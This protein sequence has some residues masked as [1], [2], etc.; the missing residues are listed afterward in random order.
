MTN[1]I[2][3]LDG[4][5]NHDAQSDF[6]QA[7]P[8][9][10]TKICRALDSRDANGV[11]QR[12]YYSSGVGAGARPVSKILG[13]AFGLGIT[14]SILSAYRWL[15]GN[16]NEDSDRLFLFGFSRGAYAVRS[17]VGM[18]QV[19][20]LA[21]PDA[22]A[23][24]EAYLLY[25]LQTTGERKLR[26]AAETFKSQQ[27]QISVHFIGVWDTVGSVGLPAITRYRLL[28]AFWNQITSGTTLKRNIHDN[29]LPSIVSHAY[30]AL[31]M[32]E[33]RFQFVPSVWTDPDGRN[34]QNV[35]QVWFRGSHSNIGGGYV[36]SGLSDYALM[37]MVEKAIKAGLKFNLD[38][39][40]LRAD[41]NFLGALR[42]SFRGVS[43]L[44]PP[45]YREIGREHGI[46]ESVHYSVME[47]AMSTGDEPPYCKGVEWNQMLST[48]DGAR[49]IRLLRSVVHIPE[50]LESEFYAEFESET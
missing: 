46:N 33:Y 2:I 36:D 3:A 50:E 19:C 37:W 49:I 38:Y 27:R 26:R 34:R 47:R 28:P 4:T 44:M 5:W 8:T 1:H 9:N 42:N 10:V 41:P 18:L 43:R 29:Y 24:K 12:Y 11:Q 22:R 16:Y 13:G 39:F 21:D 15:A 17:L 31:A 25:R 6:G 40:L 32:D 35:E 30:Q 23:I 20:G 14:K 7:A 45:H 48:N